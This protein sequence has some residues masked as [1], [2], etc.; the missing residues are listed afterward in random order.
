MLLDF[1]LLV[2]LA[3]FVLFGLWFGFVHSLGAL[4]G[5]IVGAMVAGRLYEPVAAWTQGIIP[6]DQ[7]ILRVVAFLI[8][9]VVINRLVGLVFYVIERVFKFLSIIPFLSTIDHILG[10]VLGFIEGVIVLGL[11]LYV[12]NKFPVGPLAAMINAS[13]AAHWLMS[14]VAALVPLLPKTVQKVI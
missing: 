1:I 3:G 5:T 4:L 14:A 2:L 11:T 13:G 10:A 9:F 7:N 12:A 8:L 6:W